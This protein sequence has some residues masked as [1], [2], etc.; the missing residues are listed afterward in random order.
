M[1]ESANDI[2]VVNDCWNR[3]GVWSHAASRCCPQ[4]QEIVHC[5]NCPVF[6]AAARKIFE[7][8]SL[9]PDYLDEWCRHFAQ[10]PPARQ[11][12]KHSS[13]LVFRVGNEALALPIGVIDEICQ[14]EM[15]HRLPH[16]AP[17]ILRGIVNIHGQLRLCFSLAE[18]LGIE[19]S[20]LALEGK[21][22]VFPRMMVV[23]RNESRFALLVDEVIG[24]HRYGRED[25]LSVPASLSRAL[26]KFIRGIFRDGEK[27]IGL[28]DEELLFQAMEKSLK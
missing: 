13:A 6:A 25:I 9:P 2:A 26:A 24:S 8:R 28:L 10:P 23:R 16:Y 3:I 1:Q 20:Q 17:V 12:L 7:G 14:P 19:D 21:H 18:L 22:R 15:I 4:L 5:R 11:M 27:S